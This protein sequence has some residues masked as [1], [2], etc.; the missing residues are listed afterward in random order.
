MIY[1]FRFDRSNIEEILQR[2]ENN[3]PVNWGRWSHSNGITMMGPMWNLIRA[4]N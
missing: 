4:A 1:N 3:K 2:I